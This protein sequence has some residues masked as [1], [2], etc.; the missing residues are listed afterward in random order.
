MISLQASLTALFLF[1][2]PKNKSRE[3]R[4]VIILFIRKQ[5]CLQ[6]NRL[7]DFQW[8]SFNNAI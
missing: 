7:K 5:K 6:R 8:A 1:H 4:Y 3:A 2:I